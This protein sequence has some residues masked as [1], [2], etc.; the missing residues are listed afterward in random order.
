MKKHEYKELVRPD[1]S[2]GNESREDSGEISSVKD[3][4]NQNKRNSRRSRVLLAGEISFNENFANVICII[5]NVSDTGALLKITDTN[6]VPNRFKLYIPMHGFEVECQVVDQVGHQ[7]RVK[8][9]GEK[10]QL[11]SKKVQYIEATSIHSDGRAEHH[12]E[13]AHSSANSTISNINSATE[14]TNN[15][16]SRFRQQRINAK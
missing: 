11:N 3:D 4:K 7:V 10:H 2:R 13:V 14:N 9:V 15:L 16:I 8:Y 1:F 6:V 5:R 12:R